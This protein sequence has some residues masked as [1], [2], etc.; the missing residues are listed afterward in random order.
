MN[1]NIPRVGSC[2]ADAM[3][4]RSEIEP[5]EVVSKKVYWDREVALDKWQKMLSVGHPSYLPDAVA[6]M[7]VVEF[8]HFYGAQR[9]VADWPALRASLSAAA[10]GQAATYDMAWSR[11]V[12][13]GWNLKPTKDFYTMPKRRKQFLLC[14]ARSPGK[15]IY[16]LAKD[17]GLQYRRAHEHAQRLINE[18][19]LRA[20]E[21]VEGGHRKRKL[22]PC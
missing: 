10:I 21:V 14:V 12:S 7:E 11:L 3:K 2:G 1:S 8:I 22:Y 19:K 4:P 16:E 18:G 5:W 15:S 6:T 17:L 13:G 9:F 20:A